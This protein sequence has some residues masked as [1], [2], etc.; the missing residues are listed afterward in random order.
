MRDHFRSR[1]K[2]DGHTIRS[3]MMEN[4][5]LHANLVALS[6]I[7]PELWA[8]KVYTAGI[9]I[10]DLFGSCDLDL[11]P[12]TFI[13]DLHMCENERHTSRLPKVIVLRAAN[14]YI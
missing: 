10:F 3:A 7:E 1:D 12:M 5:I 13:Y 2:D 14:A 6:F 9:E 8:N 4:P 11:D